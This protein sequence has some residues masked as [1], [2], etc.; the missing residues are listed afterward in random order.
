MALSL[1]T[2][3]QGLVQ[4]MKNP[5]RDYV[6]AAQQ[7][8]QAYGSY[9]SAAQSPLGVATPASIQAA[10]QVLQA[11]LVPVFATSRVLPQTCAQMAQ[12]FTAFWMTPPIVFVG[13]PPGAV[14]VV[15]GA[16]A[17][18]AAL[19]S[20]FGVNFASRAQVDQAAQQLATALDAFTRTVIV[21][22]LVVPTPVI[23]PIT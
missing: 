14:T 20:A 4:V 23:G 21:T 11:A 13:T 15:P 9:A 8:A 18:P 6:T 16:A 1:P 5:A 2:L 7:W 19:A 22:H 12:A 17:L 3:K 10:Q